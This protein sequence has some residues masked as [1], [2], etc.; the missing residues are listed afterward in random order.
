MGNG[1]AKLGDEFCR[2]FRFDP[3]AEVRDDGDGGLKGEGG[4]VR[5]DGRTRFLR[6][7]VTPQITVPRVVRP[8]QPCSSLAHAERPRFTRAVVCVRPAEEYRPKV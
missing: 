5:Q 8:D 2:K 6:S 4:G 1:S 7:R 3:T